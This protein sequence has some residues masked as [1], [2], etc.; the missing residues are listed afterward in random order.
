MKPTQ[1][2][3]YADRID[4][5]VEHLGGLDV[6]AVPDLAELARIAAM[7][8]FHFHRIFRLMTGETVAQMLRRARLARAVPALGAAASVTAAAGAS[9]YATSQSFARALRAQTGLSA[10]EARSQGAGLDTLAQALQQ[11]DG[12]AATPM[13]IDIVSLAPFRVL[14]IRNVGA[15]EELN[16]GYGRLFE[17]VLAQVAPEQIQGIWGIPHEDPRFVPPEAFE[18]D[19]ALDVGD[20]GT[21]CGELRE[22]R[23]HGGRH[24]RLRHVGSFDALPG[25]IDVLYATLLDDAAL[26][27]ADAPLVIH[28]LDDPEQ[29][30]EAELRSDCYLPLAD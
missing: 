25:L 26:E 20:A 6:D 16:A 19:C 22:V 13:R 2:S 7:S 15:Y 23:I 24:L 1:R 8:P 27:P 17:Q 18:F 28:Y 29:V 5:V 9:G 10:R 4:R 21:A 12:N 14:A 3:R 11:G 30:P